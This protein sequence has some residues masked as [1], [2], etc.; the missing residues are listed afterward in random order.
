MAWFQGR[1]LASLR[2]TVRRG[3]PVVG[4][5]LAGVAAGVVLVIS[6]NMGPSISM[7]DG[8]TGGSTGGTAGGS[9]GGDTSGGSTGGGSG[10]S[11][12]CSLSG[13]ITL[14][15]PISVAGPITNTPASENS[16]HLVSGQLPYLPT[17]APGAFD[18][19][20]LAQNG[21]VNATNNVTSSCVKLVDGPFV[22]TDLLYGV[23]ANVGN[24]GYNATLWLFAAPPSATWNSSTQALWFV[25]QINTG[26]HYFVPAG[27]SLYAVSEYNPGNVALSFSWAGFTPYQ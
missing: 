10:G 14:A 19:T 26:M 2:E 24:Q 25:A 21:L 11:C 15:G 4:S 18:C 12:N 16:A 13:P 7:A 27:T 8:T 1:Q 6:C 3:L 5:T 22:L 17:G 9:T 23:T 20:A